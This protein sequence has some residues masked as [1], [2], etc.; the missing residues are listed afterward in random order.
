MFIITSLETWA[1]LIAVVS[2]LTKSVAAVVANSLEL[3]IDATAAL[4]GLALAVLVDC[5]C[6]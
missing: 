6:R 4:L 5:V 2:V 3:L 1:A